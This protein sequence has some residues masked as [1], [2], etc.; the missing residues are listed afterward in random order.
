MN[1]RV[2]CTDPMILEDERDFQVEALVAASKAASSG[3][4]GLASALAAIAHDDGVNSKPFL[5]GRKIF[6]NQDAPPRVLSENIF[7]L[8]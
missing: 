1:Y 2:T 5:I 4:D 6:A 8:E 7:C 3:F